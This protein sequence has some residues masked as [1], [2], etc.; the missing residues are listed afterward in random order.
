MACIAI[1]LCAAYTRASPSLALPW[2]VASS[3]W[4]LA[5][6]LPGFPR[7]ATSPCPLPLAFLRLAFLRGPQ[8]SDVTQTHA[9]ASTERLMCTYISLAHGVKH[10]VLIPPTPEG[11]SLADARVRHTNHT[12]STGAGRIGAGTADCYQ[13]PVPVVHQACHLLLH[14]TPGIL[15][16]V[17]LTPRIAGAAL[18]D[19]IGGEGCDTVHGRLSS[20][21]RPFPT[22]PPP[23]VLEK[24]HGACRAPPWRASPRPAAPL[25]PASR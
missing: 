22:A 10:V 21:T 9:N 24:V 1:A 18:A 20:A 14:L 13:G 7:R 12:A 25:H 23:H 3:A 11:A 19:T 2:P 5:C 8:V 17:H 6:P 4:T 16:L 15:H